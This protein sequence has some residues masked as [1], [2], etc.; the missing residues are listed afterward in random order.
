MTDHASAVSVVIC[1]YTED[2]W[3]Y[4]LQAIDSVR[5]QHDP[6]REII[7][8]ID[9]NPR[10]TARLSERMGGEVVIIDSV[11]HKGKSGALNTAIAEAS[12]SI[13]ALLDDDAAAE[14]SWLTELTKGYEDPDILGIGGH[15]QPV[16]P[17]AQPRWFPAEFLWVVGCTYVGMP[18][19]RAVVRNLIGANMS[20]RKEVFLQAG[21][22]R[23]GMGPDGTALVGPAR[24]EDTE[25]CVRATQMWP[26]KVWV[27]EPRARVRHHVPAPRTRWSYFRSRCY[28]EGL[29]KAVLGDVAGARTTLATERRY[30]FRTLPMGVVRGIADTILRRD[31]A[32]I[33]RAGAIVAGLALTTAGY[34]AGGRSADPVHGGPAHQ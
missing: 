1:A 15:L 3:E 23:A 2:R 4:L 9:H 22:S 12:G 7:V 26:N 14:P 33:A 24:A 19:E 30:S 6:P 20:F 32:G 5:S 31:P 27:Y 16:W 17:V 28:V 29:S 25:F 11:G 34:V 13:I 21:G 8:A 10:L 18:R